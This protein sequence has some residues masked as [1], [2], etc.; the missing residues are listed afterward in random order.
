M[1]GVEKVHDLPNQFFRSES[2]NLASQEIIGKFLPEIQCRA[3]TRDLLHSAVFS[4]RTAN[5][6]ILNITKNIIFQV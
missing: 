4:I 2:E 1:V 6:R 5:N 3:S